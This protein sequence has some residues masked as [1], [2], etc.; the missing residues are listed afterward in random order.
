MLLKRCVSKYCS[1]SFLYVFSVFLSWTYDFQKNFFTNVDFVLIIIVLSRNGHSSNP[2]I[3]LI[4]LST[5]VC[6]KLLAFIQQN[7]IARISVE[8]LDAYFQNCLFH[9]AC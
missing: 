1:S 6:S 9:F 8:F 4:N 3:P 2:D 7:R 5:S